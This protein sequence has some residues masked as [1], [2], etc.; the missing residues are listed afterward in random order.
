M[1]ANNINLGCG[2]VFVDSADWINL[3]FTAPSLAVRQAN[4][5][6][7][8]PL[9]S[10]TAR[11]VYASHFLEHIP[12]LEVEAFLRECL[13]VQQRSEVLRMVLPDLAVMARR[14]ISLRDVGNHERADFL[15]LEIIDQCVRHQPGGEL[16]RLYRRLRDANPQQAEMS[17]FLRGGEPA[18]PTA[19]LFAR[20]R[21]GR[22]D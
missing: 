16:G 22:D 12:R 5:L 15:V 18:L 6:D 8:L 10:N 11:L 1:A 14:Y 19:A 21:G 3:D 4:L 7:R 9:A 17:A 2:T 13:R 20:S